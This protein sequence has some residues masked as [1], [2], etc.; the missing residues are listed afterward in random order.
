[1]TNTQSTSSVLPIEQPIAALAAGGSSE[2]PHRRPMAPAP[3]ILAD[4]TYLTPEDVARRY[5]GVTVRTLATWRFENAKR[6]GPPFIKVG[7]KI[8]Y[9]LSMLLQWE[10]SNLT[11][12]VPSTH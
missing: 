12:M 4:E 5:R 10:Q 3:A 11:I 2:G 1:M 7:L 6:V 8:Y 9:P